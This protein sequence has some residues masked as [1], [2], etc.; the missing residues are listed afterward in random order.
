MARARLSSET[1]IPARLIRWELSDSISTQLSLFSKQYRIELTNWPQIAPVQDEGALLASSRELEE[2]E[3][4]YR[5]W[6]SLDSDDAG[7]TAAGD[8]IVGDH[9]SR[10]YPGRIGGMALRRA[11]A[12]SRF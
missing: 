10:L 12:P 7:A 9:M 6:Q 1:P 2:R 11:P 5:Q 8:S 3:A 4:G